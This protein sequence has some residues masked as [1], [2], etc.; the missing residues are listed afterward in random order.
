MRVI[1]SALSRPTRTTL[2]THHTYETNQHRRRLQPLDA[3]PFVL[4]RPYVDT[5]RHEHCINVLPYDTHRTRRDS[6]P[7][8]SSAGKDDSLLLSSLL[9]DV[10][11]ER[12]KQMWSGRGEPDSAAAFR[13]RKSSRPKLAQDASNVGAETRAFDGA[14]STTRL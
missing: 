7:S 13:S 12:N 9:V 6:S 5:H 10:S 1:S 14:R 3:I 2:H 8:N 4:I 11:G